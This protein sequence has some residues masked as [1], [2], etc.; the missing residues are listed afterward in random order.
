ML[1]ASKSNAQQGGATAGNSTS[2]ALAAARPFSGAAARANFPV[3]QIF[4]TSRKSAQ[5]VKN[6]LF[7][8]PYRKNRFLRKPDLLK[9][10]EPF[11]RYRLVE[12]RR[13]VQ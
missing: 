4:S 12:P 3:C 8:K 10:G 5:G 6:S 2:V 9:N 11:R 13:K 1:L 7:G